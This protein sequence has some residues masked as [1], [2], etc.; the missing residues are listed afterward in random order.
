[1]THIFQF[2][3]FL[4]GKEGQGA[5]LSMLGKGS[6]YFGVGVAIGIGIE[7]FYSLRYGQTNRS[8]LRLR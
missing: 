7:S 5:G 4:R 8:R 1:M 3:P 2:P 6:E